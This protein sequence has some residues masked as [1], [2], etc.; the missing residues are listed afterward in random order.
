M[1]IDPSA[2]PGRVWRS[3]TLCAEAPATCAGRCQQAACRG[4][5]AY[6]GDQQGSCTIVQKASQERDRA[7]Q[8]VYQAG[9][10]IS[11]AQQQQDAARSADDAAKATA[12]KPPSAL[13]NWSRPTRPWHRLRRPR[14]LPRKRMPRPVPGPLWPKLRRQADE[15]AARAGSADAALATSIR[16]ALADAQQKSKLAE[17]SGKAA[18]ASVATSREELKAAEE[19]RRIASEKARKTAEVSK[20][21]DLRA[22]IASAP[23][24]IDVL[25]APFTLKIDPL[26][27]RIQAGGKPLEFSASVTPDFGFTDEVRFEWVPPARRQRHLIHREAQHHRQGPDPGHARPPGRQRCR[28][29]FVCLCPSPATASTTRIQRSTARSKSRSRPAPPA[30]K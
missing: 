3:D 25:P 27:G 13:H 4:P 20:P 5:Q 23:I 26:P 17:E 2:G 6:R 19:A 11:Q 14:P 8:A 22:Q 30:G 12:K 16:L 1:N 15:A 7:E 10:A 21:R 9:A 29:R 18:T 28:R 24:R